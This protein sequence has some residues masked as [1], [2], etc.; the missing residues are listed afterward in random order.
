[1]KLVTIL[2]ARP[3]FIKAAAL[4]R[5]IK[6]NNAQGRDAIREVIVH[7]GQHFDQNMSEVFFS[8]LGIPAPDYNL[9][10]AGLSHGAMTGRMLEQVETVLM[11]EKPDAVVVYGDTNSTLAGSLAAAK[12]HIPVA[13]VEAGLRSFNMRMPEEVNRILSDR[14]SSLLFCPT[15]EAII[16]LSNEGVTKGVHLAGDVMLDITLHY[17]E[18]AT[19]QFS[20]SQWGLE[21][22][23]YILCTIHRAENT[24]DINRLRSIL[25]AL[26]EISN[27]VKIVLPLHPR[28]KQL[29]HKQQM[30]AMLDGFMVL[31]PL[32]YLPMLRLQRSAKAILTDSGGMQK[33]AF[34]H[35]VPCITL[36]DESEWLETVALGWNRIAGA[37]S[38]VILELYRKLQPGKQVTAAENPYGDGKAAQKI[39]EILKQ[40]YL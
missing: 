24:D 9:E 5:A 21:E 35:Q 23:R 40:E 10:I 7:T 1:M 30:Q 26:K 34:F 22:G 15:E 3:Q 11:N 25:A 28:T 14:I 2:G 33:E 13:H 4:S 32:P 16:N 8:D 20:L 38:N 37:D 19:S 27:E 18:K 17:A 36:R 31:D 29:I 39:L 12:L 6:E